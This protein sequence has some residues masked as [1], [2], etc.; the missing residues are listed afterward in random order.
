MNPAADLKPLLLAEPRL[1]LAV[2][3]SL[4]AG[5]VQAQVAAVSGA[6]NYFLGGVTAYA[7]D[8]KVKLLGVNRAH[9]RQVDCVSQRVAVE[10][11]QG[12]CALFGAD[13]AVATT[14][15]A[16]P[17][18]AAGVKEPAAWWAICHV[19]RG[20]RAASLSGLVEIPGATRR[21]AQER[22]AAEVLGQ[23]AAY[24]R[25]FRK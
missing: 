16:E 11:A 9:A 20:G 22:V 17:N 23:L 19:R 7:L 25:G 10:M 8:A 3:E 13:L 1:T 15:Y 2:A 21:Q 12:A 14:G 5:H 4:T 18:P 6:S 24:L